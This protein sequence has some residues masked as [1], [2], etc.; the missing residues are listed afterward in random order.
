MHFGIHISFH[1][2]GF[3]PGF[4]N[5]EPQPGTATNNIYLYEADQSQI[6]LSAEQLA[7]RRHTWSAF[8]KQTVQAFMEEMRPMLPH[9]YT[10][11][12]TGL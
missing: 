5:S 4:Q 11:T 12:K 6:P 7:A 1:S 9:S 8:D 2:F 10:E 3:C